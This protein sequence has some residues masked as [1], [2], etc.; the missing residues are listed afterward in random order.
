MSEN[1]RI[2]NL[3]EKK[4]SELALFQANTTVFQANTN[5]SLKNLE[6]QVGQMALAMQNQSRDSFPSDTKKNPKDCMAITMRSGREL[7]GSKKL[8]KSILM[9]KLRKHIIIQQRVRKSK[10]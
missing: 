1:K 4:F 6:T 3:H 7:K 9:L 10:A 2:L 8:R 5:A